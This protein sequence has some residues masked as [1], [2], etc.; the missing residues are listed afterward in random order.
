MGRQY[1]QP[2]VFERGGMQRS[3]ADA[4]APATVMGSDSD[5]P[6]LIERVLAP[7]QR[8]V[9]TESSSGLVLLA[10]TAVALVWA[11]SPWAASYQHLWETE[12]TLGLGPWSTRATLHHLIND[13]LMAVFFFLVGLEIKREM[14]AG[15]LASVQRAAL[16]MVGALGGMVIPASI[17]ALINMGGPGAA[18]WGVPMATDI[19]FALGVLALLGDRIPLGVRVFLAAL[20]IVDDIG[21]VLVIAIFYSGGIAWSALLSAGALVLLAI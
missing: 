11:N 8:F 9:Q 10:C 19:A 7:F 1:Q 14:L 16:P 4:A 13:G 3:S 17:Y 6:E 18:G 20:A 12:L 5:A 21:A 2:C 15:E